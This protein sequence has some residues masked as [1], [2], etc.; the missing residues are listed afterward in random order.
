[1]SMCRHT[2]TYT[3]KHST[4]APT[5]LTL[6]HNWH[7]ATNMQE[8]RSPSSVTWQVINFMMLNKEKIEPCTQTTTITEMGGCVMVCVPIYLT[9]MHH[10]PQETSVYAF[11]S[12]FVVG[13]Y[14]CSQRGKAILATSHIWDVGGTVFWVTGALLYDLSSTRSQNPGLV[15]WT[16]AFILL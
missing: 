13:C 9:I 8:K 6:Q 1:M 7:K 2:E 15:R 16:G 10:A 11:E 14:C 4:H 3:Y 12:L 5:L